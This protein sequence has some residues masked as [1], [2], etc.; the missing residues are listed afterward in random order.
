MDCM[1]IASGS[2]TP[3]QQM[4][5]LVQKSDLVIAADGGA[6]HLL[7]MGLAPHVIIGD[8]DSIDAGVKS[9]LQD[10]GVLILPFPAQKNKTDTELCVDYAL[11]QGA[12]HITLTGVT[13]SRLD[14]T[15]ANILLLKPLIDRDIEAMIM[16][17]H[18]EI[19]LV[20]DH[21]ELTGSP[22][23]LLSLVPLTEKVEGVTL[24]GLV[25]PLENADISMGASIGVSNCFKG[26]LARVR[27][28][29]GMVMV[30]KSRD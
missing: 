14:H 26:T 25:Y 30:I 1:I 19:Y 28:T 11:D 15:L 17:D 9:H 8:L 2:F 4:E 7:K 27:L 20:K 5:R 13:G 29:K 12:R 22:G 16:D 21:L 3:T 23:D 6:G 24:E 10:A 18:N